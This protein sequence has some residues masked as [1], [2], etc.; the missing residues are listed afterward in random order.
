M[1]LAFL[2]IGNANQFSGDQKAVMYFYFQGE[3]GKR[4][5]SM[6]LNAAA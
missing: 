4:G 1:G 3:E 2:G 5:S 6:I